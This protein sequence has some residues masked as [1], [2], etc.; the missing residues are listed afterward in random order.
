VRLKAALT[1]S[2]TEQIEAEIERGARA[3]LTAANRAGDGM[4]AEVRGH[5]R[6]VY[7]AKLA[8]TWRSKIYKN[9]DLAP[10]V[11]QWSK[12]PRQMANLIGTGPIRTPSGLWIPI[13]TDE[14]R[15]LF[16][17]RLLRSRKRNGATESAIGK[18]E[19]RLG[20]PL[21]FVMPGGAGKGRRAYLVADSVRERARKAKSGPTSTLSRAKRLKSGGYGKGTTTV[22][23]FTLVP[24]VR[25]AGR[26][27]LD[28][29][30]ARWSQR[31]AAYIAEEWNAG[32]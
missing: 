14:A 1:G 26:L 29:I 27:D 6:R 5:V 12:A 32:S 4:K 28:A 10:A 3:V 25:R 19:R 2:L 30:R 22:V 23:L 9:T 15:R 17:E 11:Y 21:R 16:P 13:P 7:G 18:V 31:Y 24:Q 8:K 20:Q